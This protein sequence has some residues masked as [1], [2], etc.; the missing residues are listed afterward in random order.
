MRQSV[1]SGTTPYSQHR[2]IDIR[3]QRQ[4]QRAS[5]EQ[6]ESNTHA[7]RSRFGQLSLSVPSGR[8]FGG[9]LVPRVRRV[10][11]IE[12]LTYKRNRTIGCRPNR[13][14]KLQPPQLRRADG[15]NVT[16]PTLPFLNR[17]HQHT[18]ES[19]RRTDD[20]IGKLTHGLAAPT[21]RRTRHLRRDTNSSTKTRNADAG[22]EGGR[23]TPC[24]RFA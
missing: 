22:W 16:Q 2:L 4:R 3:Q 20:P 8:K 15:A 10:V 11:W 12:L 19:K 5:G 13:H 18:T 6:L 17:L 21:P 7:A 9:T 1:R 14:G 23:T 24:S